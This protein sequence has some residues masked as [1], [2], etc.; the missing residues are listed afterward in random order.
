VSVEKLREAEEL[1][2][3]AQDLSDRAER[4]GEDYLEAFDEYDRIGCGQ[5]PSFTG[6]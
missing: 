6:T 2:R 4:V 5:S 1:A 3:R